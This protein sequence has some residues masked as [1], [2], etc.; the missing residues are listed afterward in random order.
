MSP[1]NI[2][3]LWRRLKLELLFFLWQRSSN[4]SD[5]CFRSDF[6]FAFHRAHNPC[7]FL[8]GWLLNGGRALPPTT[9]TTT[10]VR[11]QGPILLVA[12]HLP[13]GRYLPTTCGRHCS[14][15]HTPRLGFWSH[16]FPASCV[17]W[18]T[19]QRNCPNPI[20]QEAHSSSRFWVASVS[21]PAGRMDHSAAELSK[22]HPSGLFAP[23]SASM[24]HCTSPRAASTSPKIARR[25]VFFLRFVAEAYAPRATDKHTGINPWTSDVDFAC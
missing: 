5:I 11:W 21:R 1:P 3:T 23:R 7:L 4:L 16:Q 13:H 8:H 24:L 14:S 9:A 20:H 10:A 19:P 6:A 2:L 12:G 25:P 15:E 22:L 17:T 18:T